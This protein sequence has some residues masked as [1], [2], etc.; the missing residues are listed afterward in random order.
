MAWGLR[1]RYEEE[2]SQSVLKATGANIGRPKRN[3]QENGLSEEGVV[4]R[5]NPPPMC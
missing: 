2:G 5:K 4:T 1:G 3:E